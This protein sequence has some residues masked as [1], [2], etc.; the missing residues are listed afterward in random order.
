MQILNGYRTTEDKRDSLYRRVTLPPTSAP[1]TVVT[2]QSSL[3][4]NTKNP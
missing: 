3:D 2:I 1:S 4:Q